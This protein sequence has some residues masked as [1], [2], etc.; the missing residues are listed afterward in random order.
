M[1]PGITGLWQVLGRNEIPFSEMVKLDYIY[2][3]TWSLW[4]DVRLLFQTL[5]LVT[6]GEEKSY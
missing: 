3:T 5:P 1:K 2:V 6:K 4:R